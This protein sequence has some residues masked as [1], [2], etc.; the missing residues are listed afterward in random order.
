MSTNC[1]RVTNET[2]PTLK[3]NATLAQRRCVVREFLARETN[4]V[5]E[6][7]SSSKRTFKES[8][9]YS[10]EILFIIAFKSYQLF[11][12]VAFKSLPLFKL[13]R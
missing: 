7:D 8:E 4:D 5:F 11:K 12:F 1:K 9:V 10:L 13:D 2:V 6:P 3:G